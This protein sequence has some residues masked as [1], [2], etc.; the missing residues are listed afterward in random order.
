MRFNLTLGNAYSDEAI[1][2]AIRIAQLGDVIG[3]LENGL[4]TLVGKDG[5]K[6]SGG[7]RQRVA[8]ARMVLSNPKAVIFDEST[9]ALDVHTEAKLFE[10][11]HDFLEER[12]VIT[13]AHRLSTIK[14]AEFIYVLEEGRVVDSGTPAQLLAKDESYFSAML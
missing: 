4:D 11:L 9:S 10:A 5:I 1:E 6:L 12:T 8:I 13:I 14:S 7:Q 2:N 3:R